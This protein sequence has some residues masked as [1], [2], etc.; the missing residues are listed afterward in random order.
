MAP[1]GG[2]WPFSSTMPPLTTPLLAVA[3]RVTRLSDGGSTVNVPPVETPLS[4]AVMVTGVGP[5]T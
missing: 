4:V 5:T 1:P 3:G 2:A